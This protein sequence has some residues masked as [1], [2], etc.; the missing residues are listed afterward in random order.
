M[1]THL[2]KADIRRRLRVT[3][4][5]AGGA[6]LAVTPAPAQIVPTGRNVHG[7]EQLLKRPDELFVIGAAIGMHG[8]DRC[9]ERIW[10]EPSREQRVLDQPDAWE[11]VVFDDPT[12][13]PVAY[14]NPLPAM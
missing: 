14:G 8:G 6:L 13:A 1:T 4:A 9:L 3:T 7:F 12:V 5:L 2:S 11:E 10:P